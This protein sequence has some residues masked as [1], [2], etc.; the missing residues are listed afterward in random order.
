[1]GGGEGRKS[2]CKNVCKKRKTPL[3]VLVE[4]FLEVRSAGLYKPHLASFGVLL[5]LEEGF[6]SSRNLI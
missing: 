4:R 6:I 1:M 2:V 5:Y 3:Q